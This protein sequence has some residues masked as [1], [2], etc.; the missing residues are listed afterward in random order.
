[1]WVKIVLHSRRSKFCFC[2]LY[3]FFHP[4]MK[5]IKKKKIYN[6]GHLNECRW[7]TQIH[8]LWAFAKAQTRSRN[9]LVYKIK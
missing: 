6:D 7:V 3:K 9:E 2:F 8:S 5:K 1:M 4:S